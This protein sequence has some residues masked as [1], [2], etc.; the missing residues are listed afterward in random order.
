MV[1]V[2]TPTSWLMTKESNTTLLDW[3]KDYQLKYSVAGIIEI[4]SVYKTN[5]LWDDQAQNYNPRPDAN[6]VLRRDPA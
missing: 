1:F 5:Y 2:K 6:Y 3:F 4:V